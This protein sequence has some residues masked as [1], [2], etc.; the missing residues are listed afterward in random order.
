[1]SSPMFLQRRMHGVQGCPHHI[2]PD[3]PHPQVPHAS[4]MHPPAFPSKF[5]E[6][7]SSV[8]STGQTGHTSPALL[9]LRRANW[10]RLI[11]PV[12][13]LH[14]L[15]QCPVIVTDTSP[16]TRSPLR[17][18][19][20]YGK[21]TTPIY[22]AHSHSSMLDTRDHGSASVYEAHTTRTRKLNPQGRAD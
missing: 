20:S 3:S 17:S 16:E 11:C 13:S 21:I 2:P 18:D 4:H 7:F 14:I 15:L 22:R 10:V 12:F 9:T 19:T 1:M 5:H 8:S 6:C